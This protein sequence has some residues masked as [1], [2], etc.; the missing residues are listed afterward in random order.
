MS[1]SP[2]SRSW[3][4]L[5][6]VAALGASGCSLV[7][8]SMAPEVH[9]REPAAAR[10]CAVQLISEL[11]YVATADREG[12]PADS[13]GGPR[14]VA[15]RRGTAQDGSVVDQLTVTVRPPKGDDQR[16]TLRVV[17]VRYLEDSQ[18]AL[19]AGRRVPRLRP[20][21]PAEGAGRLDSEGPRR[22]RVSSRVPRRDAAEL[23]SRCAR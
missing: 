12:A 1:P 3:R 10:D 9:V 6:L 7:R 17:P 8:R 18:Q 19:S 15:E 5:V 14:F 4:P 22:R 23:V 21:G 20:P 16:G 13:A 11:G 2:R